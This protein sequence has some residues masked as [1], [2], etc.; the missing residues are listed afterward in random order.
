LLS[1]PFAL[2]NLQWLI[3]KNL[4]PK[5]L[6]E[7]NRVLVAILKSDELKKL[8]MGPQSKKLKVRINSFS[9]KDG[10]PKDFSGNGGGFVFDCRSLENPGRYPEYMN[11][12]GLDENVISFLREKNDV[13]EFLKSI[14]SIIDESVKNYIN[15]EFKDLMINF[16]C[17]GGQHRSVYCAESL[18]SYLRKNFNVVVELNHMQ[19]NKRAGN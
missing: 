12:T 9:Y 8:G 6:P 16:G 2:K 14:F 1:I 7:L 13:K 10:L 17:T 5:K 18:A 4:L 15:R 11:S 3:D 19:L